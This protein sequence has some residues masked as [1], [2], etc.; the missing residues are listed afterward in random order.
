MDSGVDGAFEQLTRKKSF[1]QVR[2]ESNTYIID[3][4]S[5]AAEPV[6]RAR[7][8]Q[9]LTLREPHDSPKEHSFCV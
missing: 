9:G 3:L 8:Q 4:M 2:K 6:R 1:Y 5:G 7:P